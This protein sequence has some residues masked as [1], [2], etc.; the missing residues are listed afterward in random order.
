MK[1]DPSVPIFRGNGSESAFAFQKNISRLNPG[2]S[3]AFKGSTA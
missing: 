2:I 1:L 3:W